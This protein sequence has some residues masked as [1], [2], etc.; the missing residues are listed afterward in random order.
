MYFP[1]GKTWSLFYKV[2]FYKKETV[3]NF[4]TACGVGVD[5]GGRLVVLRSI[6]YSGGCSYVMF[7]STKVYN[8]YDS[9]K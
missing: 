5:D 4:K 3:H 2:L 6:V 8:C 1:R 7:K 9:S